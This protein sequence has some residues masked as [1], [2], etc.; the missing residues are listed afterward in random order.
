MNRCCHRVGPNPDCVDPRPRGRR[1]YLLGQMVTT[2]PLLL[3]AATLLTSG[4]HA[5][6]QSQKR[7][8]EIAAG[9]AAINSLLDTLRQDTRAATAARAVPADRGAFAFVLQT[10]DGEISYGLAGGRATRAVGEADARGKAP[11]EWRIK[12]ASLAAEFDAPH[13]ASGAQPSSK[14]EPGSPSSLLTVH[15]RW[16][17][18]S[19][20]QVDPT[21]RFDATFSI[22]RGYQ[23]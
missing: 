12:E 17:G 3:V 14:P 2:L 6:L 18:E 7:S 20:R 22:G 19:K 13:T 1:A 4:I 11:R 9:Y 8:A 5:A 23:R 16:R 15:I 21:R 10:R